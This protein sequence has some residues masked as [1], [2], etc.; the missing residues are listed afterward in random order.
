MGSIRKLAHSN[1]LFFDFRYRGVRCREYTLLHDTQ[2]NRRNMEKVLARIE[3]EIKLGTFDYAR[4]FPNST[5][6]AKLNEKQV[7]ASVISETGIMQTA[8]IVMA[9]M[10]PLF[11]KFCEEWYEENEISWKRSYRATLRITMDKY[12]LPN[13]GQ[14]EVGHITKGEILKFRSS[15]AKVQNGTKEGISPDRINHIMTPL[16]MI[17]NEAADRYNFNTPYV[18]IKQ[19][20]VSKSDIDPFNLDE[21]SLFL[22]NI[23]HDF[24]NYYTVRFFTG[25]RTAEIDGL[26]WKYVD[27]EKGLIR[28]RETLVNGYFETT[29]TSESMRDVVMSKPVY[30]AFKAQFEVTGQKDGLV[31]CSREGFPLSRNNVMNRIWYPTLRRLGLKRRKPYQ[32]RHTTAT[33]WLAAGENPEWIA[34]QMGHSTT[35]MLFTVYS[36]Y[37]P[38]LTRKDGSAFERLL[39]AQNPEEVKP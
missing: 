31:F 14:K 30:E 32:T 24:K 19:L 10:T 7:Q 27:L 33:L 2:I 4:F 28:V 22:T 21:I 8:P 20:K 6:I 18:G 23:R 25:L 9:P 11:E 5:M 36:R 3:S 26:Q 39:I 37:I 38:N 34:R 16:R 35:R 12:L 13:F 29:K 17:L 1:M 15:L